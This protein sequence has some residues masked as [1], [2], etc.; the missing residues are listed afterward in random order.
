MVPN[1]SLCPNCG[2]SY[3][4]IDLLKRTLEDIEEKRLKNLKKDNLKHISEPKQ[5]EKKSSM[6]FANIVI[7]III[8]M[9][10]IIGISIAVTPNV[11]IPVIMIVIL[12]TYFIV[13][14]NNKT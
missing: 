10:I 1:D 11:M 2:K 4:T 14:I 3:R 13:H 5:E 6:S 8:I 7:I 12:L 9:T